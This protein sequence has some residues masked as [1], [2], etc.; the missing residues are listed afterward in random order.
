MSQRRKR[1]PSPGGK[2]SSFTGKLLKVILILGPLL[3]I[4]LFVGLFLLKGWI[5]GYRNSDAFRMFLAGKVSEVLKSEVELDSLRWEGNSVYADG[6]RARGYEDAVIAS[7]EIDG[8]RATFGGASEGAWQVP[9]SSANRMNLEFSSRRLAGKHEES[10][11]EAEP[12]AGGSELPDWLKPYLPTEFELGVTKVDAA[13]LV[14]KN[15]DGADSFALRSVR[16]EIEPLPGSGWDFRGQGGDL[17]L[18]GQPD[19]DIQNFRVRLQGNELF[20]NQAE[21]D[22]YDGAR[23]S[24]TGS[25]AFR[26]GTPVDLD[27][28]LSNLDVKKVLGPE[29]QDRVSGT[30]RG[31]I[32]VTGNAEG[33]EG[34]KQSGTLYLDEG[35]LT[36]LPLLGKIADYTRS[37]RFRRLTLSKAQADFT[38]EG[39][40]IVITNIAIQS[41]G[42]SRLEGSLIV[43]GRALDGDFKLGVTPGT[44]RWIP[45]AEQ[46]VFAGSGAGFLWT[47]LRVAGT[48]DSPSEDLSSRLLVGA[49]ESVVEEAPQKA[50]DTATDVIRNPTATPGNMIDEGKKIIDTLVPLLGQ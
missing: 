35:L 16:T 7:V 48:L 10:I 28:N 14:V 42:L 43:D 46:K 26:E 44:L 49:V 50:I 8:I 23:L 39:D 27:V 40:R 25:L 3:L 5:E 30:L 1:S 37:E 19:L 34:L 4:L 21:I 2:T 6:F 36:D 15:Q 33:R 32:K 29:W 38:R 12:S 24:I 22:A 11:P 31:E 45:G 9:E 17:F 20:I 18:A 41:D 13:T 47:D